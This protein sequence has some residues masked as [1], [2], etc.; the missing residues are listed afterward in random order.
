MYDFSCL[1]LV[2][3]PCCDTAWIVHARSTHCAFVL[4]VCCLLCVGC[5]L[6]RPVCSL[7]SVAVVPILMRGC[8]NI[9]FCV[10]VGNA[11]LTDF[12]VQWGQS[13]EV[14]NGSL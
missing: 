3:V 12:D 4:A 7:L 5:G 13:W 1:P 2:C 10:V 8:I 6:S 11:L 14:V 9:Y